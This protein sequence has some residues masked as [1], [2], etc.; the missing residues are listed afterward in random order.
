MLQSLSLNHTWPR[1]F[2]DA[3]IL[4]NKEILHKFI[5]SEFIFLLLFPHKTICVS[6]KKKSYSFL[7]IIV[8]VYSLSCVWLS[9]DAMDRRSPSSSV[10][11]ILQ[12]R[13][14]EW[15]A[16]S[17]SP[18]SSQPRDW[19]HMSCLAVGDSL[20]VTTQ[21]TVSNLSQKN[22]IYLKRCQVQILLLILYTYF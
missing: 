12:P 20:P 8:V 5:S 15:V 17:F 16:I 1:Q 21:E 14:V 13:I 10:H 9:Y 22:L 2:C 11:G 4:A 6:E 18:G 3:Q 19:T 7:V